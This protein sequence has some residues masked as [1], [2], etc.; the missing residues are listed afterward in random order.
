[1]ITTL[2]RT[3]VIVG[4]CAKYYVQKNI[5]AIVENR[6]AEN[7]KTTIVDMGCGDGTKWRWMAEKS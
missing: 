5:T 2:T 1:M 3:D 7:K 6:I 4:N